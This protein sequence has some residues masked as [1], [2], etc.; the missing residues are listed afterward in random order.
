MVA[1]GDAIGS[2]YV[3]AHFG[4]ITQYAA[5]VHHLQEVLRPFDHVDVLP[6]HFYQIKQGARGQAPLNGPPLDKSYVDDQVRV[7]DGILAGTLTSVPYRSV[8]RNT[9]IATVNS[10]QVV[11]SLG[12]LRGPGATSPNSSTYHV[13]AIP[14]NSTPATPDARYGAIDRIGTTFYLIRDTVGNSMYLLVGSTGALLIGTGSGT[15]GLQP[16]AARLAGN[17]PLSVVVTSDDPGQVGGLS[18]FSG[19]RVYLPSGVTPPAGVGNVQRVYT[20]DTIALGSNRR[21]QPVVLDVY[22]LTGHSATGITLISRSDRVLFSGDALGMQAGDAGLIL[23]TSL[24]AFSDA[25]KTWRAS[26]DGKYDVLYTSR[27][28]QWFTAPTYVNNLQGLIAAAIDERW[29]LSPSRL[30]PGAKM[31]R[32]GDTPDS[33]ATVIWN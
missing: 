23:Q 18:Q 3:W 14:G 19:G 27:N 15:P 1:T 25:L 29:P 8:G 22:P 7:A 24:S 31:M 9:V 6:A 32:Y 5:S 4:F 2:A 21:G 11:Y 16:L 26:T 30:V 12:N 17:V 20:G 33:S 13:I 28:H 10:A